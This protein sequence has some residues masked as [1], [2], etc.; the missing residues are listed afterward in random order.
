MA[1]EIKVSTEA[2]T[3][4]ANSWGAAM[5]G[6][7]IRLYEGTK[8][9]TANDSVAGATLLAE[10][11]FGTPAFGGAVDGFITA[12]PLTKDS[13]AD[14]TGTAEFY[15]LFRSDGTTPMGDGTCG[16]IGSGADLEMSS[17]SVIEHGEV[18]CTGFTH[19]EGLG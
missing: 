11:G 9:A 2:A 19:Q 7:L 18:T 4:K 6:G 1:H 13:D 12:L 15:R 8:P 3:I 17:T 14:A 10:V 5:D 16:M